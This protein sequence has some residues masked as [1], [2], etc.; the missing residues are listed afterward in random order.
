MVVNQTSAVEIGVKGRNITLSFDVTGDEPRVLPQHVRWYFINDGNTTEVIGGNG[1]QFL[2]SP[3]R[4]VLTI[5]N[6]T[7]DNEGVYI[8]SATNIIGTGSSSVYVDVEGN[9]VWELC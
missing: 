6:L 8:F 2:F 4:K 1:S 7:L 5:T 9:R 3:D